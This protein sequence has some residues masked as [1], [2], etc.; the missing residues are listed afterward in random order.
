[1]FRKGIPRE[2]RSAHEVGKVE[3][4]LVQRVV[5]KHLEYIG[6]QVDVTEKLELHIVFQALTLKVSEYV[7]GV[8]VVGRRTLNASEIVKECLPWR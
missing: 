3:L 6:Q 1:M 2:L 7:L 8:C 4:V 5:S